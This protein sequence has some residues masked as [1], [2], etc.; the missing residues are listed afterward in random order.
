MENE[1]WKDIT[2]Y[3]G[4]YQISN[5]GRVKSLKR[6]CKAMYGERTVPE[7]ILKSFLNNQGY[8]SIILC[9]NG[10]R[11]TKTI[12]RIVG[13]HFLINFD[14]TKD[15]NHI[16]DNKKNNYYKNLESV[17]EMENVCH[18]RKTKNK[19]KIALNISKVYNKFRARCT[20]N[21]ERKHLG[22]FYTKEEAIDAYNKFLKENNISNKYA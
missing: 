4:L 19:N 20:F 7:K 10:K 22:L 15:I 3:K 13:K 14:E 11:I 17:S 16:D 1:I 5:Y 9:N 21:G 6:K 8:P 12:H 2:N 18:Y